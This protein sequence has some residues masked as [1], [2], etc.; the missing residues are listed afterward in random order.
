VAGKVAEISEAF[1]PGRVRGEHH[2]ALIAFGLLGL[3]RDD[4]ERAFAGEVEEAGREC[5]DAEIEIA[6]RGR[7]G[8]RLRRIEEAR[9]DRKAL[10]LEVASLERDE[11]RS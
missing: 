4:L 2:I 7:D 10:F 11:D 8:D 5:R 1:V 6:R 3:G 9:L